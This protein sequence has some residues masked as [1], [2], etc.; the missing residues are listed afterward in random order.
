MRGRVSAADFVEL[1]PGAHY[2]YVWD[3][4]QIKTIYEKKLYDGR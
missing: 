2:C 4:A 1:H 3:E